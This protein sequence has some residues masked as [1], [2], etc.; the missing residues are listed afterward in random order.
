MNSSTAGRVLGTGKEITQTFA[1]PIFSTRNQF[2]QLSPSPLLTETF[3]I[4]PTHH[5]GFGL[6]MCSTTSMVP[7]VSTS[8]ALEMRQNNGTPLHG[9]ER[10]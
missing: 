7:L 3:E 5:D 2:L 1:E 9:E 10:C 8:Y 6:L 4:F